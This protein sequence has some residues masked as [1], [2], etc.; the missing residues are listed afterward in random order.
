MTD[1]VTV[2]ASMSSPAL[3]DDEWAAENLI[4]NHVMAA[5]AAAIVPLPM[6]DVA[7]I[8]VVQLRM[9]AKLAAMYGKTFSEGPVRNTI[10]ALGGGIL[11][12]G[13]GIMLGVSL[14]KFIPGIG[15]MLGMMSLPVIAGASTYA[16]GRVFARHFKQ[17]GSVSDV[18]VDD[19]SGYYKEQLARGKK[20]ASDLK[21][22]IHKRTAPKSQ[23]A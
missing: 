8:T 4:K 20:V 15:W 7:A 18:V 16:V 13:G 12:H 23:T 19:V 14:T 2:E 5:S 17:G 10:T 21:E 11:G 6:F 9:I 3:S 1:N 22:G